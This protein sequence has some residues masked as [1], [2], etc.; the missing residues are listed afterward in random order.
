M[1]MLDIGRVG[2]VGVVAGLGAEVAHG[3]A[4]VGAFDVEACAAVGAAGPDPGASTGL[5][6]SLFQV[7]TDGGLTDA[8]GGGNLALGQVLDGVGVDDAGALL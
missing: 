2:A 4:M 3:P 8:F 5:D 1:A 7:E 6:A